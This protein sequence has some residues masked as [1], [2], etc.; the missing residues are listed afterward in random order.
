VKVTNDPNEISIGV[1]DNGIGFDA[2]GFCDSMSL[3]DN[4]DLFSIHE[5]MMEMGGALQ[6]ESEPGKGCRAMLR[7]PLKESATP[8][9]Q[10]FTLRIGNSKFPFAVGR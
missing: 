7:L 1:H 8:N 9:A 4:F 3:A 5:R 10:P 6:I 2:R